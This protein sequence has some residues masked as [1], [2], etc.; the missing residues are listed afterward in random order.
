MK[1]KF[2]AWT[3]ARMAQLS[4]RKIN[5]PTPEGSK[6]GEFLANAADA[7]MLQRKA[8]FPNHVERCATCAFRKGTIAN[9]SPQTL[10]D[11]LDCFVTGGDFMCHER[12]NHQCVGF[13]ILR[14]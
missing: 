14:K 13:A 2:I 3:L 10:L 6:A 5:M 12:A 1:E 8:N 7:E 9:G 11:A 4:G